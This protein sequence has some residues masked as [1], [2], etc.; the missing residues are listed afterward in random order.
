MYKKDLA[1]TIKLSDVT[2]FLQR[3]DA[4]YRSARAFRAGLPGLP[5]SFKAQPPKASSTNGPQITV[6]PV[7]NARM[8][9]RS[10]PHTTYVAV[11][12]HAA[13]L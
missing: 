9:P 8:S 12:Y 3:S 13:S 1:K 2:L 7:S 5:A 6:V 11:W 10:L 4:P